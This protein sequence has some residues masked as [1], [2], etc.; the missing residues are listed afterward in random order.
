[1]VSFSIAMQPINKLHLVLVRLMIIEE[2]LAKI[3]WLSV[4]FKQVLG[5]VTSICRDKGM[6]HYFGYFFEDASGFLGIF[7]GLCPD[8][9][10]SFLL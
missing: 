6:C 8:F 4:L 10:V 2:F 9:W 3:V 7:F 5:R 1:M